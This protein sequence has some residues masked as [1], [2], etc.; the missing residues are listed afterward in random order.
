MDTEA[1]ELSVQILNVVAAH[2]GIKEND[3]FQKKITTTDIQ[4][5]VLK[6]AEK[7]YDS[8]KI[9]QIEEMQN[10]IDELDDRNTSKQVK[11]EKLKEI[12]ND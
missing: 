12:L 8:I 10:E 1:K 11:L 5:L 6:W 3:S 7:D 4:T 2:Y 9:K